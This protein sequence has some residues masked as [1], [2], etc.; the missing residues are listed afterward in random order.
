LR[1]FCRTSSIGGKEWESLSFTSAILWVCSNLPS[2]P[3]NPFL[4]LPF[5]SLVSQLFALKPYRQKKFGVSSLQLLQSLHP[6]TSLHPVINSN[7]GQLWM[8]MIP[9]MLQILEGEG[10]A[11]R[12]R[13]VVQT[14]EGLEGVLRCRMDLAWGPSGI[15]FG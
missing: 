11:G 6:I 8:K 14:P 9:Q 5:S 3:L 15:L 2:L 12:G 10:L 1:R 4:C 13:G 7:V